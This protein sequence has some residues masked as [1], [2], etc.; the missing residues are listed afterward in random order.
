MLKAFFRFSLKCGYSREESNYLRRSFLY[1]QPKCVYLLA[2]E[3]GTVCGRLMTWSDEHYRKVAGKK[4]GFFALLDGNVCAFAQLLAKMEELQRNWENEEI[5]GPVAPDGSGWFLGQCEKTYDNRL[6]GAFTGPG[7][8]GQTQCFRENGYS[9][10]TAYRTYQLTLPEENRYWDSAQKFSCRSE[11]KVQKMSVFGGRSRLCR[12]VLDVAGGEQPELARQAERIMPY[13][14]RQHSFAVT[15]REGSYTGYVLCFPG[16]ITRIATFMTADN[17]YRR[18]T[19]LLL[20]NELIESFKKN[21]RDRAELSVLDAENA[22][23]NRL[24]RSLGAVPDRNYLV[25]NKKI[26]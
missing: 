22:N 19:T 18:P 4:R 24:A 1:A 15:N 9:V 10:L 3:N 8:T 16:K 13:L 14:S 26:T 25:Y 20:V 6:R 7:D 5:I 11:Y 2:T 23:S 12:S 17:L 21:Q